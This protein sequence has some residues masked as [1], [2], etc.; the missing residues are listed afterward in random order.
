[1]PREKHNTASLSEFL[2]YLAEMKDSEG[3]RLPS[4]SDLSQQ[5][6]VSIASLREQME[7]ARSMGLVEVRP[8]TGIR[9]LPYTF[10]P[11]VSSSLKYA[12]TVDPQLFD[13]F[14]DLRKHIEACY[15]H[16]ATCLLKQDDIAKLQ[17][18]IQRAQA[19]LHSD[20]IQL[21]ND[22]HRELH[23]TIYCR[24]NNPFVMGILESYW[25]LYE[26][27]GLAVYADLAYH[28]SV[29]QYHQKMVQALASG[30]V[31]LGYQALVEHMNLINQRN[32]PSTKNLSF[33]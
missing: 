5:L 28:E 16:E 30:D 9:R 18:L 8:K 29:W 23:L 31:D 10:R 33:E 11:A 7:V 14:A 2:I 15:W 25:E 4:L 32:K 24:L 12:V 3:D 22:E 20:P 26:A 13:A 17:Y 21:P 19:K 1:M 27:I 6:G